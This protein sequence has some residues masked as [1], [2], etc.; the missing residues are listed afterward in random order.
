MLENNQLAGLSMTLVDVVYGTLTLETPIIVK[1]LL[2]NFQ[3][4]TVNTT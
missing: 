2:M 3:E 4:P 1:Q